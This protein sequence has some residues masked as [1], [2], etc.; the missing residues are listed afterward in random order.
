MKLI[1]I[2][3]YAYPSVSSDFKSPYGVCLFAFNF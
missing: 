3:D 1:A 2:K